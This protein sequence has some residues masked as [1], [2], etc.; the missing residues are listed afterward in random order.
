MKRGGGGDIRTRIWLM[1][2]ATTMLSK[3]GKV[4]VSHSN[5]SLS[6]AKFRWL[7]GIVEWGDRGEDRMAGGV[8]GY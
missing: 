4:S 3:L 1:S 8:M 5:S 6:M 2:E 7:G